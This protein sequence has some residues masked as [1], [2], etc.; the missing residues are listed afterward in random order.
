MRTS[1]NGVIPDGDALAARV[2]V[3]AGLVLILGPN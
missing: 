2:R 1:L 3:G